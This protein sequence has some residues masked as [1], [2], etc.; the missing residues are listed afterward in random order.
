MRW[1]RQ[2]AE[3]LLALR[4]LHVNDEWEFLRNYQKN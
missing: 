1:S 3:N 4:S 2:G